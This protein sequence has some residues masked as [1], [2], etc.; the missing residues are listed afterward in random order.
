MKRV[1]WLL[2]VIIFSAPAFGHDP[3]TEFV[4]DTLTTGKAIL[5]NKDEAVRFSGMCLLLKERLGQ[6]QIASVWLGNYFGLSR[7]QNAI[8]EFIGMVPSMLMTKALPFLG[9]GVHGTYTVDEH[10]KLRGENLFEVGVTIRTGNKTYRGYVIV[11]KL[12]LKLEI[13]DI[14]YLGMSLVQSQSGEYQRILNDEYNKDPHG[15]LPVTA[16]VNHIKSQPDYR[17]CQ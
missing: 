17:S 16:L 8:T 1:F 12:A 5:E 13:V 14:E 7:D 3:V 11:Q 4:D 6:P 10:A 9:A 2:M 15:S